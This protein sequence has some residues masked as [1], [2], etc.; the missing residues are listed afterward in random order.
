MGF[1]LF[2]LPLHTPVNT[3]ALGID[4]NDLLV[5]TMENAQAAIDKTKDAVEYINA[6]RASLGAITNRLEFSWKNIEKIGEDNQGYESLL[7]DT[8][9]AEE[10]IN[11]TRDQIISQYSNAMLAQA[12]QNSTEHTTV[13]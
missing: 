6:T 4:G 12:N 7:R 3:A 1:N 5:D 11:I 2:I 8:D 9:I 13:A 10:M